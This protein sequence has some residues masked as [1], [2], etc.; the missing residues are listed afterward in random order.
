[1][2]TISRFYGIVI[3]MYFSDHPPPHFHARYGEYT[4][5]IEIAT[6]RRLDGRLP[7]RAQ[8]LVDEWCDLHRD[9]LLAN[10]KRVEAKVP[11]AQIDP[12]P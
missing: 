4:A 5:R 12:L 9:E 7:P 10:W 6:G 11:L 2:P 8:A 3:S 1:M